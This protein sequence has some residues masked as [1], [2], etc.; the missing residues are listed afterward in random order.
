GISSGALAG[1]ADSALLLAACKKWGEDCADR[2]L[3][4]FVFA[5]WDARA[6][7]LTLARDHMGQRHL[8]F[9]RG[10]DFI[11]FATEVN[12][13]WALPDVPR[14]LDDTQ[15]ARALMVDMS[16]RGGQS[17]FA[18]VAYIPGGTAMNVGRDG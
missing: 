6:G 7:K 4:D 2:L 14:A 18:G 5:L 16:P 3:G 10:R 15:L 1:M 11:A 13:L 8:F 12:G 9:H 17:L